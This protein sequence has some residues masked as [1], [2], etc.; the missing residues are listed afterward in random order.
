M[1]ND[2]RTGTIGLVSTIKSKRKWLTK[3][4][5]IIEGSIWNHAFL[6]LEI[7][8]QLVA[9]EEGTIHGITITPL[10]E[11]LRAE[12]AG[13]CILCFKN[14]KDFNPELI[15]KQINEYCLSLVGQNMYAWWQILLQIPRQLLQRIGVNWTYKSKGY[16]CSV[17]V[18][19]VLNKF[20]SCY[21]DWNCMAPDDLHEDP[22]SIIIQ[23]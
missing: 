21:P 4:I 13:D 11:Y 20:F 2:I 3:G 9:Y 17:L 14:L 12:K 18:A 23:H 7:D 6:V 5:Q 10:S 22:K 19:N 16:V 15:K 8:G 1:L